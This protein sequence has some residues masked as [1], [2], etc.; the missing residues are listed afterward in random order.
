MIVVCMKR[1]KIYKEVL[2]NK[3]HICMC[4]I[5]RLGK[6]STSDVDFLLGVWMG[7]FSLTPSIHI[8][9]S[10]KKKKKSVKI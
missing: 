1:R 2:V 3:D 6:K 7:D 4:I 5:K 10:V 9:V 8:D